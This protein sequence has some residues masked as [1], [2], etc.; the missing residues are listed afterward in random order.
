ML[1][2]VRFGGLSLLG[3]VWAALGQGLFVCGQDAPTSAFRPIKEADM[4]K[5]FP[6]YTPVGTIE[7]KQYPAYRKASASGGGS[8]WTLFQHIKSNDIAMTAPVEMT[9]S[10]ESGERPREQKMA[11]LYG[12]TDL[13]SPGKDGAVEVA[14]VPPMTVVSLGLRGARSESAFA[15]ARKKLD[16]W[17]AANADRYQPAGP[18]R[19]MGYNSPFVPRDRQFWEVQIPI[20]P[21]NSGVA[22]AN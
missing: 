11:F 14:D 15:D 18:M 20:A 7:V 5:G 22:A 1:R 13:G 16:D 10:A 9:Y 4:P 3:V 12:S 19:V 17:L 2:S 6:D 8:F 21:A